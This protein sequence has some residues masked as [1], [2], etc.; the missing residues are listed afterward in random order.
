MDPRELHNSSFTTL[1]LAPRYDKSK[2]EIFREA[3]WLW[4]ICQ[5]RKWLSKV[6]SAKELPK[7]RMDSDIRYILNIIHVFSSLLYF[8][9]KILLIAKVHFKCLWSTKEEKEK[10]IILHSFSGLSNKNFQ[11]WYS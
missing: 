9:F 1:V 10:S 6:Y 8:A 2:A 4:P 5:T 3:T 11:E 7:I